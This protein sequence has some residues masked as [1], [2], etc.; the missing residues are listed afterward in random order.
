M[1]KLNKSSCFES[2]DSY[3]LT[4]KFSLGAYSRNRLKQVTGAIRKRLLVHQGLH[5]Y[6]YLT[7]RQK[8]TNEAAED[9]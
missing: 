3:R 4:M 9:Y 8:T 2:Y 1:Y 7:K 5:L 6:V